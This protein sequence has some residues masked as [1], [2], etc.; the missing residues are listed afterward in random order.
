MSQQG[1]STSRR[2]LRAADLGGQALMGFSNFYENKCFKSSKLCYYLNMATTTNT[3][4]GENKMD[5]VTGLN[6]RPGDGYRDFGRLTVT[7]ENHRVV[8]V[9]WVTGK[10][11]EMLISRED[12]RRRRS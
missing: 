4:K 7:Y 11:V 9:G 2:G 3:N 5:N 12:S 1:L 6:R 10:G 8:W